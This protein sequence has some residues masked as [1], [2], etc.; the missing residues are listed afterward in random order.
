MIH[1]TKNQADSIPTTSTEQSWEQ[2]FEFERTGSQEFTGPASQE[3]KLANDAIWKAFE[4]NLCTSD[5]VKVL[6][7]TWNTRNDQIT[8]KCRYP[9]KENIT[10]RS[11]SEQVAA[12]YDPLGWLTPLTLAGKRFLQQLWKFNYQWDSALSKEHQTQWK[13]IT[14][15]IEDFF[16]TIP[17]KVAQ[18]GT[19]NNEGMSNHILT[20]LSSSQNNMKEILDWKRHNTTTSIKIVMAYVL[21]FIKNLISKTSSELQSRITST[22]PEL[23]RLTNEKYVTAIERKASLQVIVRNHQM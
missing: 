18:I 15:S 23:R 12:V 5:E 7:I 8:L 17:R 13:N 3:R 9:K 22:I 11:V 1:K 6:G 4:E 21:R 10:K 19:S 16:Y 2:F 14:E 20:T